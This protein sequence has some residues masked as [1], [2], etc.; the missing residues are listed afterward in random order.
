LDGNDM[1]RSRAFKEATVLTGAMSAFRR[2]GYAG[3]AIPELEAATGISA[4]SIYNAYGDKRGIFLAAFA[5]YLK[6]VLEGRIARF[7]PPSHGLAGLRQLFLS[8]LREPGGETFGCLITNTA[9]EFGPDEGIAEQTTR[10]GFDI[11]ERLF[12]GRLTVA[13][14]SGELRSGI[15]VKS[16]S[17]RLLALY[18]GVLVLIRGGHAVGKIRRAIN[19]E[20]D[21]LERN[22]R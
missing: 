21:G 20:F 13:E 16:A 12:V 22:L 8:L 11:L 3:V 7:A 10:K 14:S 18:Q 6:A 17:T 4:G 1:V 2:N 15:E 9:V 5:H 19:L